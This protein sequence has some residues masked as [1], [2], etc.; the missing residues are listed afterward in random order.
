MSSGVRETLREALD[1]MATLWRRR[2][3]CQRLAPYV[4]LALNFKILSLAHE[5]QGRK[6]RRAILR[7]LRL[8]PSCSVIRRSHPACR[9]GVR[10]RS[11]PNDPVL[12]RQARSDGGA[13]DWAC[14]VLVGLVGL[15]GEA[16]HEAGAVRGAGVTGHSVFLLREI[17]VGPRE[18]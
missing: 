15:V 13:A 17:H 10:P 12:S 9:I 3:G 8:A 6:V 14:L 16:D 1:G 7:C 5:G 2:T 11:G 18:R 4:A